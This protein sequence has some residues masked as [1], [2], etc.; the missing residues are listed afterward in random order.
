MKRV[1]VSLRS[2][3]Y[4][5]SQSQIALHF[6]NRKHKDALLL[7]KLGPLLGDRDTDGLVLFNLRFLILPDADFFVLGELSGALKVLL[8]AALSTK[9][10]KYWTTSKVHMET[11]PAEK[12]EDRYLVITVAI[13]NPIPGSTFS[14]IKQNMMANFFPSINE[15]I[16]F[17]AKIDLSQVE[18]GS[19][20]TLGTYFI[21]Y[22][23]L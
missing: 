21:R 15:G 4:S 7:K 19:A 3:N 1:D 11:Q 17:E 20:D 9:L 10:D 14:V 8:Q 22:C 23:V 16:N 5:V 13:E 2:S 18:N 12:G 6:D